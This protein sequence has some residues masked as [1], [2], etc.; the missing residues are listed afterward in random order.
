MLFNHAFVRKM[1][2]L[3]DGE[4]VDNFIHNQGKT[5]HVGRREYKAFATH[6]N[7]WMD[8]S[9]HL[10][11]NFLVR[12]IVFQEPFPGFLDPKDYAQRPIFRSANSYMKAYPSST[13]YTNWKAIYD[14][15][16]IRCSKVTHQ[17]R[18]QVQQKLCNLGCPMDTLERFIGY[19]PEGV[20]QMNQSQKDSY[21]FGPPVQPVCGA[22]DGDPKHPELHKPGW[23][24]DLL[25]GELDTLCPWLYSEIDKI[26]T[27]FRAYPD[28]Q[29]RID[30]CLIQAKGC[31][32]AFE[33]RIGQAVLMLAS[34]PLDE[35]NNLLTEQPPLFI[36]WA[37]HPVVLLDYFRSDVFQ[38][39]CIRVQASQK[40]EFNDLAEEL[41]SRQRSWVTK[42]LGKI[43]PKLC[44]AN[45]TSQ[46]ILQGRRQSTEQVVG[47]LELAHQ[48]I[49]WIIKK[50]IEGDL[51]PSS[52]SVAAEPSSA[53]VNAPGPKQ[54]ACPPPQ[55]VATV[56]N[57]VSYNTSQN[58]KGKPRKHRPPFPVLNR[59]FSSSNVTA[60]DFW[61]EYKY[62]VN[63]SPSLE[64]LELT[65]GS[66]WRSDTMFA[67]AGGKTGTSLKAA[68][69]LRK[70]VYSYIAAHIQSGLSEEEALSLIQDVFDEYSYKN[71]GKP[72][73]SDCKKEFVTRWGII[74]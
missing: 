41:T 60:Y 6:K 37:T 27:A 39:I 36:R 49:D 11:M 53:S 59:P 7:P 63:G 44:V 35:K 46:S 5:N 45:R 33:R 20:K 32:L 24:I 54:L 13:Q 12:Y 10:G 3:D 65:F 42:E 16:G 28:H 4:D 22:A 61:L 9:A 43:M 31:L 68:W 2:F 47:S 19:K 67:C 55:F 58:S 1:A 57:I 40:S 64:N 51:C 71:S 70:P 14:A 66:K 21:L 17:N 62:G 48:K 73:L 34:L 23:C 15:A 8:T 29:K 74:H 18:S 69:S 50:L 52:G 56:N 26:N 38:D 25:P 72:K 30:M